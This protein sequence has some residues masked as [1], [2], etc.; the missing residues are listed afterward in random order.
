MQVSQCVRGYESCPIVLEVCIIFAKLFFIY[1]Y[2]L[3]ILC[4]SLR[5]YHGPLPTLSGGALPLPDAV[6]MS[7][8]NPTPIHDKMVRNCKLKLQCTIKSGLARVVWVGRPTIEL[9]NLSELLTLLRSP[10]TGPFFQSTGN[11]QHF[12]FLFSLSFP[13]SFSFIAT[14]GPSCPIKVLYDYFC[15]DKYKGVEPCVI[16]LLRVEGTVLLKP[17]LSAICDAEWMYI[18]FSVLL[19]GWL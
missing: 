10:W 11:C 6:H 14:S 9:P 15:I 4:F 2:L 18:W 17:P 5:P 1:F 19:A 7:V 12:F 3:N 8:P 16:P 13:P